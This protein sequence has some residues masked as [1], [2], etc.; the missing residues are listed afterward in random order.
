[1]AVRQVFIVPY[2]VHILLTVRH[3]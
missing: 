1:V 2:R 3:G